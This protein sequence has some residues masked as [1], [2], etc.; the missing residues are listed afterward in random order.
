MSQEHKIFIKFTRCYAFSLFIILNVPY[1][2]VL[3]LAL[4]SYL[5][6]RQSFCGFIDGVPCSFGASV[7]QSFSISSIL[8]VIPAMICVAIWGGAV[9]KYC[10]S[11]LRKRGLKYGIYNFLPFGCAILGLV[12][13]FFLWLIYALCLNLILR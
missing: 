2:L 3:G 12:L 1:L 6:S 8:S 10:K 4:P 11:K 13:G 5:H 9:G 7:G